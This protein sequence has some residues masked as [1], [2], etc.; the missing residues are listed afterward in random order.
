LHIS[1]TTAARRNCG[2]ANIASEIQA[3]RLGEIFLQSAVKPLT[4]SFLQDTS[5]R[6]HAVSDIRLLLM[7]FFEKKEG[8]SDLRWRS[9]PNSTMGLQEQLLC[10][11]VSSVILDPKGICDAFFV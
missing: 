3:Q 7:S 9:I 1:R 8:R 2:E 6:L 11:A 5:D 10:G 4:R